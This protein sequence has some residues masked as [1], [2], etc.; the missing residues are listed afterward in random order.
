MC[1]VVGQPISIWSVPE[2][3][4]RIQDLGNLKDINGGM[5]LRLIQ[6]ASFD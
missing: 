3:V 6:Y 2:L 1:V 4:T 5:A